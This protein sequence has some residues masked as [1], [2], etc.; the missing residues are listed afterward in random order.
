MKRITETRKTGLNWK[1]SLISVQ[2]PAFI[3]NTEMVWK[4]GVPLV[5]CLP[6]VFQQVTRTW[7]QSW[8]HSGDPWYTPC[9]P[10]SNREAARWLNKTSDIQTDGGAGT[11]CICTSYRGGLCRFGR[12]GRLA[13]SLLQALVTPQ[14]LNMETTRP[15]SPPGGRVATLPLRPQGH[16]YYSINL[17]RK[18]FSDFNRTKQE[19][20]KQPKWKR[21]ERIWCTARHTSKPGSI[22]SAFKRLV[23]WLYQITRETAPLSL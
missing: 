21:L 6:A 4:A 16:Y 8:P 22:D 9:P 15:R 5:W 7:S 18:T 23:H 17:R 3:L 19:K 1:P 20:I 10:F 13:A 2:F 14:L 12:C 11:A